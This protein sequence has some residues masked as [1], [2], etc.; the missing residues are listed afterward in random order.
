STTDLEV[1]RVELPAGPGDCPFRQEIVVDL[2]QGVLRRLPL[3]PPVRHPKGPETR[4]RLRASS[5]PW[6]Q[7]APQAARQPGQGLH[8]E[9]VPLR[10]GGHGPS[11]T[12]R[13]VEGLERRRAPDPL[14][15]AYQSR[16]EVEGASFSVE[17]SDPTQ[18][19][20]SIVPRGP[21]A[22]Q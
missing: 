8:E 16:R 2:P 17:A 21:F 1:P 10:R 14:V 5:P 22:L 20:R 11:G 18:L 13:L 6:S 12:A 4:S 7:P 15:D 3:V 9:Q 19:P